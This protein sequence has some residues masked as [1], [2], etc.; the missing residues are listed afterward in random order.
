M[1]KEGAEGGCHFNHADFVTVS[2]DASAVT[3]MT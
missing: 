1:I 3:L 2:C